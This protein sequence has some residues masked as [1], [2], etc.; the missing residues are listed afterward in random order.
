MIK[1][2]VAIFYSVLSKPQYDSLT[3]VGA[4]SNN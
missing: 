3:D 1:K 4:K 2:M